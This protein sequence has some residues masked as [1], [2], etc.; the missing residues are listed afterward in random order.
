VAFNAGGVLSSRFAACPSDASLTADILGPQSQPC[1]GTKVPYSSC[2]AEYE[3]SSAGRGFC[4]VCARKN[5][6]GVGNLVVGVGIVPESGR[7]AENKKESGLATALK[8]GL[9]RRGCYLLASVYSPS[10]SQVRE[11]SAAPVPLQVP[12][13]FAPLSLPVPRRSVQESSAV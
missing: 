12:F 13:P 5:H 1:N 10:H 8:V 11:P 9:K 2:N 4:V 7:C 6:T 3:L